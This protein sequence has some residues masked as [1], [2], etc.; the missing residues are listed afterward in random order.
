M[1]P[2]PRAFIYSRTLSLPTLVLNSDRKYD[3]LLFAASPS[4]PLRPRGTGG[5]A[6]SQSW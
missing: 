1:L 5:A 3:A 6:R 2:S 4:P